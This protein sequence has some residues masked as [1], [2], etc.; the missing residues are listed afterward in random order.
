MLSHLEAGSISLGLM[1]S[2]HPSS[3]PGPEVFDGRGVIF[4]LQVDDARL[5][6]ER[7]VAAGVPLTYP[8]TDTPWAQRRFMVTEPSGIVV[9]V[10]Q[11]IEPAPG[12]WDPYVR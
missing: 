3:P 12:F 9:D 11:Q 2:D 1:S 4:T 6:S 5:L 8:L 7:L 10:V